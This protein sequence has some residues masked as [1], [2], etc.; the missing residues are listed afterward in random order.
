[1]VGGRERDP[2]RRKAQPNSTDP[3]ILAS[4]MD[5]RRPDSSGRRGF[6]FFCSGAP[7]L[8][9]LVA[10]WL[11]SSVGPDSTRDHP[12]V[13]HGAQQP[14][15]SGAPELT[16]PGIVLQPVPL[17]RRED[18][19]DAAVRDGGQGWL[20]AVRLHGGAALAAAG[21]GCGD[22]GRAVGDGAAAACGAV[23]RARLAAHAQ[24]DG[25]VATAAGL[26]AE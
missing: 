4:P 10:P 24:A 23:E 11:S 17:V 1:R 2:A 9:S 16:R 19:A 7:W 14:R 3:A 21:L 8:R 20:R 25:S 26:A 22:V 12:A 13:S 15:S 6:V 5:P 18:D